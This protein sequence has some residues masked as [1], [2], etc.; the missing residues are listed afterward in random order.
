MCDHEINEEDVIGM[1]LDKIDINFYKIKK[2]K[3]ELDACE[4]WENYVRNEL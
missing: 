1:N 2:I 3:A 4:T